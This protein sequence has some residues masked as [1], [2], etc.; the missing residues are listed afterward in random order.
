MK[1]KSAT[2]ITSAVKKDQY[3]VGGKPEIAFVGR[4]NVGKSSLI[5]TLVNRRGLVKTSQRPGKTRLI[6]FFDVNEEIHMVDL[7]GYGYAAV[8]GGMK[9]QWAGF[10]EEYLKEREDL[11]LVI[12]LI[13][14]RH[15]PTDL[16]VQM[17]LWLQRFGIPNLLVATKADKISRG[18]YSKHLSDIKKKLLLASDTKIITFSA[19]NREGKED[20]WKIIMDHID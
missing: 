11:R 14:I 7:P 6:N 9:E 4:S 1:V 19:M 5:N 13:D 18:K 10:I 2:F 15:E 20:V 3:P 16:D 17:H 8:S 12:Q